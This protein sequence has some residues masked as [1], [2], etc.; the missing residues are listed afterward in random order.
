MLSFIIVIGLIQMYDLINSSMYHFTSFDSGSMN[1]KTLGFCV[2]GFLIMM[3]IPRF[4]N[5]VEKSTTLSRADVIVRSPIAMS[6]L[7]N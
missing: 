7:C 3:L 1:E 6:A 5:G 4:I 2:S